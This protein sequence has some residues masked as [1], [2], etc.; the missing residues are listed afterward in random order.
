MLKINDKYSI[1]TDALNVILY[2]NKLVTGEGKGSHFTKAENIGTYRQTEIGYFATVK[3][4]LHFLIEYEV[5]ATG[6]ND[7]RTINDKLEELHNLITT[8][9]INNATVGH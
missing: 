2:E 4:A 1:G 5:K 8:L 3:A 6:F 7:L 9:P